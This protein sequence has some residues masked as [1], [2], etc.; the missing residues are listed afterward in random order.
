MQEP[1]AGAAE[2]RELDHWLYP[3]L[4]A[5]FDRQTHRKPPYFP[6]L[7]PSAKARPRENRQY[8]CFGF[9]AVSDFVY[10][11][12]TETRGGFSPGLYQRGGTTAHP[13]GPRAGRDRG[14]PSQW[15]QS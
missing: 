7:Q 1:E 13:M 4:S 2:G 5:G 8:N 15:P 3:D 10:S 14:E 12:Q 6:H 9:E 11:L